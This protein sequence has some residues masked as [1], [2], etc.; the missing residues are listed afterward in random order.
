EA[1]NTA[2]SKDDYKGFVDCLAPASQKRMAAS[3]AYSGL[4]MKADADEGRAPARFKEKLEPLVKVMEKHGLTDKATKKIMADSDSGDRARA[5]RALASLIKDPAAFVSE[6]TAA[7][8]K[9]SGRKP[10][11]DSGKARLTEVKIAGDK[12]KGT[13]L[14]T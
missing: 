1:A 2:R 7:L 11:K 9:F 14:I 6:Y 3:M 4:S 12:A 8:E 13:L 10:G 5:E